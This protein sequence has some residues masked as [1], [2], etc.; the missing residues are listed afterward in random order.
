MLRILSL[1]AVS[2][3]A[4]VP[5]D[6]AQSAD[7]C[8]MHRSRCGLLNLLAFA[9]QMPFTCAARRGDPLLSSTFR[10]RRQGRLPFR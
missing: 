10:V 3:A 5:V 2:A 4:L 8:S 7:A 1:V 9:A 6:S